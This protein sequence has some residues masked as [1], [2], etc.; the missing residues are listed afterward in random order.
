MYY[1][2]NE[3]CGCAVPCYPCIGD[4]CHLRHVK[5]YSCDICGKPIE[6]EK[7]YNFNSDD[8]C[9]GCII[10]ALCEDEG[11]DNI[12]SLKQIIDTNLRDKIKRDMKGYVIYE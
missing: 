11:I 2:T 3:C 10:E 8:C 6:D 7:V 1:E 4:S 12:R 5:H 9:E